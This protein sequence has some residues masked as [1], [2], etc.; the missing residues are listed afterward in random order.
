LSTEHFD[1]AIDHR[2][3]FRH[4]VRLSFRPGGSTG[5]SNITSILSNGA[6]FE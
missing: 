4:A 1:N 2:G 6:E 3:G 5:G